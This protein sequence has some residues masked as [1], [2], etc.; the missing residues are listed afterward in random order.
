MG[1]CESGR[2]RGISEETSPA[3]IDIMVASQG[4]NISEAQIKRRERLS[5][6]D[7]I[8]N[9][10]ARRDT[11][12]SHPY[13]DLVRF[14]VCIWFYRSSKEGSYLFRNL[15]PFVMSSIVLSYSILTLIR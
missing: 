7:R 8:G 3:S 6:A 11:N 2:G 15:F 14:I 4:I 5:L 9:A 10:D 12:F 1:E 13:E